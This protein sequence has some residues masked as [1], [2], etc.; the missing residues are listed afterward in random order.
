MYNRRKVNVSLEFTPLRRSIGTFQHR[1][2]MSD[3]MCRKINITFPAGMGDAINRR[4]Y[5]TIKPTPINFY[6]LGFFTSVEIRE[7]H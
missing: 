1:A 4:L 7:I 2:A 6:R 5:R 3:V